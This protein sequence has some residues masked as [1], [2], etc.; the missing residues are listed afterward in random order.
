MDPL[1]LLWLFF[2]LSSLQPVLQRQRLAQM[3]RFEL[4]KL[5]RK[6]DATVITLIHRQE[7]M[8]LLGFPIMRYIDIDDA[9]SVLRAIRDAPRERP[10]EIVLHTP[11][12]VVLAASQI[13]GALADHPSQVTAVVPHYA[14]S[15]G[16]L[17]ALACD[18]I[19]LDDHSVL[20][21]VDPQLGEYAAASLVTVAALPGDHDD[22]TLLLADVARKALVQ[23]EHFTR[24]LLQQ[25]LEPQR[26]ADLAHLL[27]TGTWTHDHPLRAPEL[28]AFGLNV[29]RGVPEEEREFMMLFP[30]PRGRDG[31]VE[32]MPAPLRRRPPAWRR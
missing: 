29:R 6:R 15:G 28:E 3:R 18:E 10:I 2:I 31:T 11:G 7:T 19:L 25:R 14:M 9:E 8:S 13:A 12:G 24:E 23:V 5:S 26:A 1:S 21:P 4:N 30:P 20:G 22:R 17:I 16:T 27:A 32:Y